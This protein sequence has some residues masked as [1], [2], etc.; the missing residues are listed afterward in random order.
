MADKPEDLSERQR[1]EIYA[2]YQAL[3]ASGVDEE[4]ACA[5]IAAKYHMPADDVIE[6]IEDEKADREDPDAGKPA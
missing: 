4:A 1:G 3:I 2:D 5:Q 6:L